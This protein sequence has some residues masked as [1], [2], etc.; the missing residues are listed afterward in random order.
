MKRAA[1]QLRA[2]RDKRAEDYA[3]F[4]KRW[5][6]WTYEVSGKTYFMNGALP[7]DYPEKFERYREIGLTVDDLLDALRILESLR[8][9]PKEPF[10]YFLGIMNNKAAEL[11]ERA[12]Q[13]L[14]QE[15][16]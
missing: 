11:Q 10:S 14:T 5:H 3:E 13:I 15:G 8:W 16:E 1:E 12:R 4:H 9:S 7:D 2:E 6:S